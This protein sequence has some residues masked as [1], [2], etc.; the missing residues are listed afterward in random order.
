MNKKMK[1]NE[2]EVL[3]EFDIVDPPISEEKST[4]PSEEKKSHISSIYFGYMTRIFIG[5]F[6]ILLFSPLAIINLY[7]SFKVGD[8]VN[9][10]YQEKSNSSYKVFKNEEEEVIKESKIYENQEL[11]YI[12][13]SIEY[14][15]SMNKDTSLDFTTQMIGTL[16]IL[17]K[18]NSDKIYYQEHFDLSETEKKSIKNKKIYETS[19]EVIIDYSEYNDI[20]SKYVK[21]YGVET[22]SYL[23]VILNV[24]FKNGK[25]ANY[26]LSGES[27]PSI[28]IPLASDSVHIEENNI[29]TEKTVNK[30]PSIYLNNPVLLGIGLLFTIGAI[31]S[32]SYIISLIYTTIETKDVYDKTTNK[33][34]KKYKNAI[35]PIVKV[36]SKKGKRIVRVRTFEDLWNIHKRVKGY[37]LYNVITEHAKCEFYINEYDKLYILTIKKVDL[38]KKINS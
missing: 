10:R 23:E 3:E 25:G 1:K 11:D 18:N 32:L 14:Q 6:L 28:K 38:E 21:S 15:F 16:Y 7:K 24:N 31:F 8:L 27:K 35:K 33:I 17:D 12:I 37:I 30:K 26:R 13:T 29:N 22:E 19:K 36:P 20:A 34:L 4:E 2:I 5:V 9:V